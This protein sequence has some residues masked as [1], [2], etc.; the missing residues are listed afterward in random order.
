MNYF[1]KSFAS[2]LLALLVTLTVT[3]QV[4][5][6]TTTPSANTKFEIIAAGSTSATTSLRVGTVSGTTLLS[7][8]DNGSIGIGTLTPASSASLEVSSTTGGFLPPRMTYSQ[9]LSLSSPT[10]GLIIWCSDCVPTSA[11]VAGEMQV[12]NGS[13]WTNFSG[14]SASQ[15]P[16][17][18]TS[19]TTNPASGI[20][21]ASA[22]LSGTYS[23]TN[24]TLSTYGFVYSTINTTPSLPADMSI[25]G[26]PSV[27]ATAGYLSGNL[28]A[29]T[30][31]Q[32]YYV[33]AYGSSSGS[34]T[35]YGNTISFTTQ[36][37][38]GGGGGGGTAPSV[39]TVTATP[40]PPPPSSFEYNLN[41]SI[42]SL[43][44]SASSITTAYFEFANNTAFTGGV[45]TTTATWSP[46]PSPGG[47]LSGTMPFSRLSNGT[48]YVRAVA[49]N[50]MAQTGFGSPSAPI[51]HTGRIVYRVSSSINSNDESMAQK[52]VNNHRAVY[53]EVF[54][55]LKEDGKYLIG[56]SKVASEFS[57]A[58]NVAQRSLQSPQQ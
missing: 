45:L 56:L 55:R 43:G 32:T 38:G 52:Q 4:G 20:S 27:T 33:R 50:N 31:S 9:R 13:G 35:V 17:S 16:V 37:S 36:S 26:P 28:S 40:T 5:I 46:T 2:A 34:S 10:A 48:W 42:N 53:R 1:K 30:P 24:A 8:K 6:G 3:A 41:A 54:E 57:E 7:V 22:S 23:P 18:L 44:T 14:S 12:Y 47:Q 58:F 11:T 39:G 21:S 25:T 51:T 29:L 15:P 19:L 49:T